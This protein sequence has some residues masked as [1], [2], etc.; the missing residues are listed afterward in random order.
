M[1][2]SGRPADDDRFERTVAQARLAASVCAAGGEAL[3]AVRGRAESSDGAVTA[4][5]DAAG[6]LVSLTLTDW[7]TRLTAAALG[8][9]IVETT[10]AARRA[11]LSQREAV[12]LDILT[13]LDR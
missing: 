7:A 3:A 1:A 10:Q 6:I 4:L 12:L 8:A 5:V 13:D 9:L 2:S 11:A